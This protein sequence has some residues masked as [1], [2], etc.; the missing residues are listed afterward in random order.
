ML[1]THNTIQHCPL[2]TEHSARNTPPQ[3][4]PQKF[5]TVTTEAEPPGRVVGV[6]VGVAAGGQQQQ[7]QQD[8]QQLSRT[9][10][11]TLAL[12]AVHFT[13]GGQA[14]LACEATFSGMYS[15]VARKHLALPGYKTAAPSQ[16][17]FGGGARVGAGGSGGA[18]ALL[19]GLA[20]VRLL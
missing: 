3:V 5:R 14:T 17:L 20:L 19:M 12:K 8:P 4:S 11:L 18:A 13:A 7:Q 16:K 10:Q 6:G 15:R 2:P 9:S 1:S